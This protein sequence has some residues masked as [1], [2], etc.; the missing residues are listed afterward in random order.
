MPVLP[1]E[2]V[3]MQ[4]MRKTTLQQVA[5]LSGNWHQRYLV[6]QDYLTVVGQLW[7]KCFK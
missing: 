4:S 2:L 6:L 7:F 3:T 1:G 5:Y